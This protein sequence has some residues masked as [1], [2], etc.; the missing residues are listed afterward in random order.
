MKL[1]LGESFLKCGKILANLEAKFSLE[2]FR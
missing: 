1:N 2:E